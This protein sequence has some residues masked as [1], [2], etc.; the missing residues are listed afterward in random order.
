MRV[1]EP[2]KESLPKRLSLEGWGRGE[3]PD[4]GPWSVEVVSF[5][6][7]FFTQAA[8]EDSE[9]IQMELMALVQPVTGEARQDAGGWWLA[10]D[11]RLR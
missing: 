10:L 2:D 7:F 5:T 4:E 3:G 9:Q 11:H 1:L 6:S 8:R